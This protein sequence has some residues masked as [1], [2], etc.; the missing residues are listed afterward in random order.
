MNVDIDWRWAILILEEDG[1]CSHV[2]A[3]LRRGEALPPE[4]RVRLAEVLECHVRRNLGSHRKKLNYL[5]RIIVLHVYESFCQLASVRR[6]A[7]RNRHIGR[8]LRAELARVKSAHDQDVK[9]LADRYGVSV[10][11]IKQI[12]KTVPLPE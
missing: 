10:H 5:Q 8:E 7:A 9:G 2:A 4:A 6:E 11:T 12:R 1:D 3:L